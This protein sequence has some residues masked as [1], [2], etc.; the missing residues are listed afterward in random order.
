MPV[1]LSND[2]KLALLRGTDEGSYWYSLDDKRICAICERTLSGRDIR[3]QATGNGGY[4][5]RCPTEDCP[6]DAT[7]WLVW[8]NPPEAD[9]CVEHAEWSFL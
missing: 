2:E 9:S 6:S 3:F 7:Q 4:R 5:L 1:T 8:R